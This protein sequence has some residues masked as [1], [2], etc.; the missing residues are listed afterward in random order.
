MRF[1]TLRLF[2]GAALLPLAFAPL[3]AAQQTAAERTADQVFKNIQVF[4]GKPASEL[5]PTMSFMA[6]SLGVRCAFCHVQPFSADT[7]PQKKTARR[8]IEM[9]FAINKANFNG[10]PEIN[11]YTCHQGHTEPQGAL[12]IAADLPPGAMPAM[13]GGRRGGRGARGGG[14]RGGFDRTN[15]PT[16]AQVIAKYQ[17]ALGG[18]SALAAIRSETITASQAMFGRTQTL[19]LVK[20]G[21][22]FALTEGKARAG[23]DGTSYWTQRGNTSAPAE[24]EMATQLQ[25]YAGMYPAAGLD[26]AQ[27]RVFAR[28]PFQG[29][30]AYLMAVRTANGFERYYFD[31]QTGL[32]RRIITGT[33]TYLGMLPLQVDYSDYRSVGGG[34]KLPFTIQFSDHQRTWT[35]TVSSVKLNAAVAPG[36]LAAPSSNR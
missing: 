34:V 8:M 4:R 26:A 23:Y 21:G 12:S 11:C 29:G 9:V 20:Q 6:S 10:R 25:Q 33:P 22:K 28:V 14:A 1:T 31:A 7:K 17:D 13:A 30:Q 18:A 32:L 36:A 24:G 19:T 3:L 16:A 35:Q 5:R 27:A 2:A 15:L